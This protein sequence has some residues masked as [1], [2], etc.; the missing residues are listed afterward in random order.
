MSQPEGA[1]PER[2]SNGALI[3]FCVGLGLMALAWF[4]GVGS[5]IGVALSGGDVALI[6]GGILAAMM[7]SVLVTLG[8]LAMLIGGAWMFIQVIADQRG[9]DEARY[10]DVER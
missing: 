6:A 4:F 7:L 8:F 5:V 3:L 2:R 9:N 1:N 10:R